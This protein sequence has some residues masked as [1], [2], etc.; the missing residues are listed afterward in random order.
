MWGHTESNE[1][2]W[3]SE[4]FPYLRGIRD[5]EEDG[6]SP[7]EIERWIN[8]PPNAY[9]SHQMERFRWRVTFKADELFGMVN[10]NVGKIKDILLGKRGL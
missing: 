10:P 6:A 1:N 8:H 5:Y 2:V 4:P 3:V 7:E 9:C